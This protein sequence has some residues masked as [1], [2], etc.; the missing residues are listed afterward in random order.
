MR[1]GAQWHGRR[2]LRTLSLQRLNLLRLER[3][4]LDLPLFNLIDR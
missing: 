3:S 2:G 1:G 4:L